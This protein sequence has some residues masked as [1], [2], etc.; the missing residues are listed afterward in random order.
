MFVCHCA[1]KREQNTFPLFR[2]ILIN[3]DRV[4]GMNDNAME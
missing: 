4:R 2:N 3:G 1:K